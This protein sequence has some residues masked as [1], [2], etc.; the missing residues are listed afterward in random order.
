M[1]SS[2]S[3]SLPIARNNVARSTAS[4]IR[5]VRS[6]QGLPAEKRNLKTIST[7]GIGIFHSSTF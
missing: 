2:S 6:R 7:S 4:C 1:S 3:S 5:L